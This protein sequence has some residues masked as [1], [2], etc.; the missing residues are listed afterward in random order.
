[1]TALR[2]PTSAPSALLAQVRR[3][4]HLPPPEK[5]VRLRR[6][7]LVPPTLPLL[8]APPPPPRC[9]APVAHQQLTARHDTSICK[10]LKLSTIKHKHA[11]RTLPPSMAGVTPSGT[12]MMAHRTHNPTNKTTSLSRCGCPLL[13]LLSQLHPPPRLRRSLPPR[14][15]HPQPRRRHR[16]R[17]QTWRCPPWR[18]P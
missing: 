16:R 1:M 2:G 5:H 13:P 10:L 18:S 15:H 6:R 9:P 4:L 12:P 8:L 17:R 14:C 11:I 3:L 7:H